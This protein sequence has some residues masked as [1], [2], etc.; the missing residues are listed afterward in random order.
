MTKQ[1]KK[2]LCSNLNIILHIIIKLK[3]FN[4]EILVLYKNRICIRLNRKY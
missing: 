2:Y 3:K 4:R 1:V